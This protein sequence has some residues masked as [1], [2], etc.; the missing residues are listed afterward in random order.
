[1]PNDSFQVSDEALSRAA[2]LI[3]GG[4]LVAFPT[5]TVYG[6]GANALDASAVARIFEA[7]G[8]PHTSPLIVHVS[9]V[10]MAQKL[11]AGWPDR[12][13]KLAE[14][15]WPGPLT[16]VLPKLDLIPDLVT[17]GLRS[18]G[19]RMPA[20]RVALALISK[21]GVP[22]AAPSANRFTQLSPTTAE[23]VREGL[24]ELVDFV[25]DGGPTSV[26]IESTVVSLGEDT[27]TLLRPG[28]VSRMELERVIGHINIRSHAVSE[29]HEAPGMHPRH[30][31]P[32][33]PLLLI[34][35]GRVPPQGQGIYLKI[36]KDPNRSVEI[37]GMPT[38]PQEYARLLYGILHQADSSHFDWI[39]VALPSATADWEAVLDR[40]R[41]AAFRE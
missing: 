11:V 22:I 31:S 1:M 35:D 38:D 7:K 14:T 17:A 24:G 9:S 15:F 27:P 2:E 8:R 41:R 39:G 5:E 32:R 10:Q 21:A 3:R 16:L 20:H 13:E 25:L 19:I 28:G 26:G 40:L 23:H 36:W 30:Y 6:L 12:A 33:T 4:R 18:V 29:A 34:S 37:V